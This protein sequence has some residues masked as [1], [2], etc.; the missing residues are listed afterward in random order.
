MSLFV[1]LKTNFSTLV[2]NNDIFYSICKMS[3]LFVCGLHKSDFRKELQTMS[4]KPCTASSL[5]QMKNPAGDCQSQT[6]ATSRRCPEHSG[7]GWN[8]LRSKSTLWEPPPGWSLHR[9]ERELTWEGC[10]SWFWSFML[11]ELVESADCC[12]MLEDVRTLV[13]MDASSLWCVYVYASTCANGQVLSSRC[14]MNRLAHTAQQNGGR[15]DNKT[16]GRGH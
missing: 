8:Y 9:L 15:A 3:F 13:L 10:E 16:T 11:K 4:E 12:L 1:E 5:L 2:N 14:V 6:L 7:E